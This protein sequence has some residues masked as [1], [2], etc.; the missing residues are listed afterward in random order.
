[1]P[2]RSTE[3]QNATATTAFLGTGTMI[4]DLSSLTRPVLPNGVGFAVLERDGK[5]VM[6]SDPSRGLYEN[7]FE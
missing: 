6:H 1:M 7:F 4:P 2:I 3:E 5:V